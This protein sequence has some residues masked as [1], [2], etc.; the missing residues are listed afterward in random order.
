MSIILGLKYYNMMHFAYFWCLCWFQGGPGFASDL[1]PTWGVS[2]GLIKGLVRRKSESCIISLLHSTRTYRHTP[3][4]SSSLLTYILLSPSEHHHDSGRRSSCALEQPWA[5]GT[6]HHW[7]PAAPDFWTNHQCAWR[8]SGSQI[9]KP[10]WP[11][12]LF[13]SQRCT[14]S[15]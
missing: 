3:S 14:C 12:T 5:R 10:H 4:A 13:F 11:S 8:H 2:T 6:L 9:I 1:S 15:P 7:L